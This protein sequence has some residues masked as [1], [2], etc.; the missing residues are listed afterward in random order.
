M[1]KTTLLLTVEQDDG[2][3]SSAERTVNYSFGPNTTSP[4]SAFSAQLA[5]DVEAT[6]RVESIWRTLPTP[7]T[8]LT[9]LSLAPR[10]VTNATDMVNP[11]NADGVWFEIY[12]SP[13]KA[14]EDIA[15][16]KAY[17]L[18]EPTSVGMQEL[19]HCHSRKM[20]HFNLAV[21]YLAKIQDLVVRLM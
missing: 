21:F 12:N 2:T 18:T 14:T 6:M 3:I 20:T 11:M 16:A 17:K 9:R 19:F 8:D 13:V 5:F 1:G 7:S 4:I 10:T 15:I